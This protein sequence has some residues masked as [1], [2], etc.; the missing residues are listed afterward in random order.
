VDGEQVQS[1]QRLRIVNDGYTTQKFK[2]ELKSGDR[3]RL[4]TD[5]A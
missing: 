5:K 2:R 4:A 1:A 3:A